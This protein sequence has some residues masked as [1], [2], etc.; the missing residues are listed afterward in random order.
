MAVE[1]GFMYARHNF[2]EINILSSHYKN[3]PIQ[4]KDKAKTIILFVK[5]ARAND[6]VNNIVV[7]L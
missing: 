3:P 1:L 4:G 2:I 5:A 6:S 7:N